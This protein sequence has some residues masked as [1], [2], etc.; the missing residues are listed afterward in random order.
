M[1]EQTQSMAGGRHAEVAAKAAE[2]VAGWATAHGR[3][4][5]AATTGNVAA[6]A[7]ALDDGASPDGT[8]ADGSET[9]ALVLACTGGAPLLDCR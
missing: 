1:A 3:L 7:Q 4:I 2:A 5:K 8:T 9:P 6:L